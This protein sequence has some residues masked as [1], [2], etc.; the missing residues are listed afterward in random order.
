MSRPKRIG[1]EKAPMLPQVSNTSVKG[2]I[3][4]LVVVEGPLQL[5]NLPE[6]EQKSK[7]EKREH[8]QKGYDMQPR[9]GTPRARK[10][11]SKNQL[12]TGPLGR[13]KEIIDTSPHQHHMNSTYQELQGKRY[14]DG[15]FAPRLLGVLVWEDDGRGR[16]SD[17]L[18]KGAQLSHRSSLR[19][20]ITMG[21]ELKVII[22]EICTLKGFIS[23]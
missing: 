11:G 12:S 1:L 19:P 20:S 13:G 9:P 14:K 21:K 7:K 4:F 22:K 10:G 15:F 16:F 8:R 5:K 6:L 2:I 23:G 18:H 17:P 3:S